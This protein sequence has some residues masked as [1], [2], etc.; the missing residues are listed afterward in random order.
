MGSNW[1]RL[2]GFSSVQPVNSYPE[3]GSIARFHV[4]HPPQRRWP[5]RAPPHRRP[6]RNPPLKPV[7]PCP[8]SS[9]SSCWD[10]DGLRPQYVA[11]IYER[12]G[13]KPGDIL[14]NANGYRLGMPPHRMKA[15]ELL[16]TATR[17]DLQ[18]ERDGQIIRKT[19]ISRP[20]RRCARSFRSP[21][22]LAGG[23]LPGWRASG[24][25]GGLRRPRLPW[26][27][28]P[29]AARQEHA[30]TCRRPARGPKFDE[31]APV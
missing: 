16:N 27:W 7:T 20:G 9:R 12:L 23:R 26:R 19:Y 31:D 10:H 24:A 4:S 1:L 2:Q 30:P 15:Y 21:W 28:R 5:R 25:A 22:A 18:I 14:L 8:P 6:T 3:K 17:I 11:G 13:L 29:P